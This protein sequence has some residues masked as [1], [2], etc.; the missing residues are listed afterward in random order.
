M[1]P[2]KVNY[3]YCDDLPTTPL[4]IN[5]KVLVTGAN[6][7]VGHRLIPELVSR[8]F[9]LTDTSTEL[10]EATQEEVSNIV[11]VT[12][13]EEKQDRELFNEILR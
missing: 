7:Y 4:P 8:G 3:H 13:I 6:G 10:L 12:P 2:E 1:D 9:V 5:T 11:A